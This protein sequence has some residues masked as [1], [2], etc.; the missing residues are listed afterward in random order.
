MM[1]KI[2]LIFFSLLLVTVVNAANSPKPLYKNS[3]APIESRIADLLSRMTLE[4]KVMQ[5][6]QYTVG[7][8]FNPNNL[9]DPI[10]QLSPYLGS[11]IYSAPNAKLRNLLQH[12]A[13]NESRLGIPLLFGFDVIHG[14]RT[15]YP[16][17]LAQ[18]C[19]FNP[20]LVKE[21]ASVAAREGKA[22]G[23]DWFFSP[24]IDV[25]HDPRWG[26]ISEG[27]GEDPFVTA[28]FAN[29]TVKGFQGKQLNENSVAACLKHFVGYGASEA[30]RDYVYT[31]ISRPTLWNL[32]LTPYQAGVEAGAMTLMSSFNDI[33]GIPATANHYLLTDIL[34]KKWN[35]KGFVVSDWDGVKQLINQGYARDLKDCAEKSIN[36]GLDVDMNSGAYQQYLAELVKEGHVD[37]ARVNDAVRRLLRVKFRLG[38]FDHPY[39]K[40]KSDANN[41]LLP[42]YLETAGKLAEETMVLLKNEK[43]V[44]PLS[45]KKIA[46]IGP[47]AKDGTDLLGNWHAYGKGED[48]CQIWDALNK[49]FAG[50]AQLNY[51]KGCSFDSL[52]S[53]GLDSA[54]TVAQWADAII[55]CM[56][57]KGDWT[58][59]NQSRAHITLPQ[60]QEK[61]IQEL[62]KS[63]KPLI[64]VLS[65]GRPLDLTPIEPYV[66]GILEIW[67]PGVNGASSVAGIL[68]GRINPSGKLDITFP[69]SVAQI[70]IYYNRHRPA[71]PADQGYYHDL[72][73]EP[74]YPF[75]YGLSYTHFTYSTP[76][77][78]TTNFRRNDTIQ[79]CVDVTNDGNKDG[80]ETVLWY[81]SDPVSTLTRPIKELRHFEK[82]TISK[83]QTRTFT[84]TIIPKKDLSYRDSKGNIM[85]E[86]GEYDVI[87]GD[88]VIKLKL[89]DL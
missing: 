35:M 76:K 65:N 48:V 34:K 23:I 72:S 75:G 74:L 46:V 13:I 81:I 30:G 57:E 59:E 85:L 49:E 89:K 60:A 8:N 80:K 12:K 37:T 4:E 24:M 53:K 78:S 67:Q 55:L 40:E 19:S 44:L 3:K 18:G 25:C 86:S 61:L 27:Y 26:R 22:A 11:V 68:S 50:K 32:Y 10:K 21:A 38:L 15:V 84:F 2:A 36:A 79:I 82:K 64:L 58:G 39:T 17:G 28:V 63:G 42:S 29:A 31:E 70:P 77:C 45:F 16:I 43:H 52:T 33:S 88:K 9:S 66:Q 14:F 6:N 20:D 69:A 5:L 56:G 47:L 1:K 62:A 41:Y 51:V 87:V 71:R 73:V 83:G 7:L 54:R